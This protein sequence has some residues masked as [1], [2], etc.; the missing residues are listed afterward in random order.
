VTIFHPYFPFFDQFACVW[1]NTL[2]CC[3]LGTF[4]VIVVT[5]VLIPNLIGAIFV[6]LAIVSI[7]V[8]VIGFMVLWDIYLDVISMI[9]LVMCIGFSVD[10]CAHICHHFFISRNLEEYPIKSTLA[11][12]GPPIVQ[13]ID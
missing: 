11:A 4:A 1:S 10:F 7:E 2:L 9:S 8:G 6:T 12:Y 5:L 3:G 13:G